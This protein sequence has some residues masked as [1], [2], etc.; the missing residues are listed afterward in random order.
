[1][2]ATEVMVFETLPQYMRQSGVKTFK[3]LSVT[4]RTPK[5]LLYNTPLVVETNAKLQPPGI[6]H[7]VR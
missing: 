7:F 1:M 4:E 5:P 6:F 2:I 3:S